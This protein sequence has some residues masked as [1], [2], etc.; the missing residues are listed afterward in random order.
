[1]SQDAS[2]A[3]AGSDMMRDALLV[4]GL[5]KSGARDD[6]ATPTLTFQILFRLILCKCLEERSLCPCVVSLQ[7]HPTASA[8]VFAFRL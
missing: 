4:A 8:F 3:R 7:C 5:S 1:M 2:R 6:A